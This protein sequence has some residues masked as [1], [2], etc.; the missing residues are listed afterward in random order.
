MGNNRRQHGSEVNIR[1][2][3]V[4]PARVAWG[5]AASPVGKVAVGLTEKG[6]V[7][8]LAFLCNRQAS[9]VLAAWRA[10][11]PRTE[12]FKGADVTNY[13]TAPILLIG[14]AFQHAVWRT[15][16]KIPGGKTLSYGDLARRIGNPRAARAV[17]TAC[18][19]NPVP[20]LVP[21]HRIV[22]ANG[23]GGF[24]SGLKIKKAL[25]KREGGL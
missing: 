17:G 24:S 11:W 5:I 3:F 21:C 23:L 2:S 20:L 1:T 16:T 8:R 6:E 10:A 22:A 19:A 9:E 13:P 12:F 15:M 25:L 4:P 18:G 14:T 7:C